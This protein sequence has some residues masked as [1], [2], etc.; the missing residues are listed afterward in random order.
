M[1]VGPSL[2]GIASRSD[3]ATIR[4][5]ILDPEAVITEGFPPGTMPQVWGEEL[6][7]QQLDDIV[8]YLMTLK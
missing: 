6:S 2:A 3:E 8:A 7:D 4:T 5:S 1:I